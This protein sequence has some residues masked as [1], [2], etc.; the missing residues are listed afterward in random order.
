MRHVATTLLVILMAAFAAEASPQSD[1]AREVHG[2][3][4]YREQKCQAC[5][6]IEGVGNRRFPLDG[7]GA[8]L[9]VADIRKWIVAPREM[10][11]RVRK[12]AY[13]KL[14]QRDLEALVAYLKGLRKK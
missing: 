5:H 1:E 13:D 11:P 2:A 12:K 7:V 9:P 8:K 3:R 4:V 10:N 14:A 6:S